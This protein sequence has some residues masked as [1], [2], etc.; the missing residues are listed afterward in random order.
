MNPNHIVEDANKKFDGAKERFT[1]DL[2]KVRT[3]RAFPG[4]RIRS[5]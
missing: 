3:G 4:T 2:K 1:E 5:R